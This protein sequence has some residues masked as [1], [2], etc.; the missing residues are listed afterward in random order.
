MLQKTLKIVRQNNKNLEKL[1]AI[2]KVDSLFVV[3]VKMVIYHIPPYTH[4]SKQ[5]IMEYILKV[6]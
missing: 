1:E 3:N 2:N 6:L 4:I 5:S